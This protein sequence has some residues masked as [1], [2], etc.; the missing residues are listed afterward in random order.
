MIYEIGDNINKQT[1][2]NNCNFVKGVLMVLVVFYH[3]I[4]FW[5]GDWFT[6]NPSRSSVLLFYLSQWLN[7]FHIYA[8]TL[9][10]GY[11]FY[12]LKYEQKKYQKFL[13]FVVNKA[14]RLLIPY[15]FIAVIW[16]IPIQSLFFDYSML[17]LFNKYVLAKSPS[18]L[19]FLFM[20]FNVFV[21]FWFLSDFFERHSAW[22]ILIVLAFWGLSVVGG[23]IIPNYFM[24]W[25]ACGYIPLFWIGF[26]I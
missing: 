22:G 21:I 23:K 11:L 8:F 24:I 3:C 5:H 9:V 1:E 18:Q 12:Y 26:K 14:K 6:N 16:V 4:V 13:P 7:S 25:T 10:S 20:L 2:L 15:V 19:W 17:D